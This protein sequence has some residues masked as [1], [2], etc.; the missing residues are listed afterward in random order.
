MSGPFNRLLGNG[1]TAIGVGVL[2]C[3]GIYPSV[4]VARAEDGTASGAKAGDVHIEVIER[5]EPVRLSR[6]NV[7]V[8]VAGKS[9]NFAV[10]A[11]KPQIPTH[12]LVI[13]EKGPKNTAPY[14]EAIASVSRALRSGWL[15]SM[16]RPDGYETPYVSSEAALAGA[17]GSD[18]PARFDY[19]A[20]FNELA[21]FGGR[22]VLILEQPT[23]AIDPAMRAAIRLIP[24]VYRV[25][26]G[27]LT[28]NDPLGQ[29]DYDDG[30]CNGLTARAGCGPSAPASFEAPSFSHVKQRTANGVM[31]EVEIGA[32][33]KDALS[34]AHRYYDIDVKVPASGLSGPLQVTYRHLHPRTTLLS[35]APYLSAADT[36]ESAR[37]E[38]LQVA[39]SVRRQ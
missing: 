28:W 12:L 23:S 1:L 2:I 3:A 32:A 37:R 38:P 19:A 5:S 26:G 34:D 4:C 9:F 20:A 36:S 16:V 25:D 35:E 10:S 39:Y 21:S 11:G 15:V 29:D 17:L 18:T 6:H 22:R 24:E 30:F 27:S 13:L 14:S 8:S 7:T 33:V 31:H